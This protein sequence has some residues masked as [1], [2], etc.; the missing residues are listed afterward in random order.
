M[1]LLYA[2]WVF[3]VTLHVRHGFWSALATLGAHTSIK[4]RSML[5]ALAW[6]VAVLLFVG[7]MI[8][9]VGILFGF[10]S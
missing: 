9:P 3:I 8:M 5:N 4:S 2:I 6:I 7:F 10:G 1:V